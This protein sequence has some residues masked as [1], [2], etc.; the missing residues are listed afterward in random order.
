MGRN[1]VLGNRDIGVFTSS[2]SSSRVFKSFRLSKLD[3]LHSANTVAIG[4][5]FLVSRSKDSRKSSPRGLPVLETGSRPSTT[6]ARPVVSSGSLPLLYGTAWKKERTTDLVVQ[7]VVSGFRGIDTACQ[8]KHY[9]E[10]LV[11][12]ALRK[13]REQYSIDRKDLWLQTKFTPLAG[14]DKNNVPYDPNATLAEQAAQSLQKSLA[15]LGTD[16]IDSLLLHSP[17]PTGDQTMEVW[18]VFEDAVDSGTVGQLGI[19]NLYDPR[20]FHWLHANSRHKPRVLQNRFYRDS[21]YDK[22][23]RMLCLERGVTY[24]TFWTLT[25]NPHILE[26]RAVADAI[27]RLKAATSTEVTPA[28]VLFKFLIQSGHQPVTGTTSQL[29]MDQ[30][31]AAA[32]LPDLTAEEMGAITALL[33]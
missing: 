28:Q 10:D 17:L 19:S 13:L 11:G 26:S 33:N 8:P 12:A 2:A 3:V 24:Q 15:N 31:L 23:L 27:G 5:D 7:A 29:H 6:M 20:L 25:A 22:E 30:D 21:G 18:R 14:Q 9:R 16:R 1:K 4:F 32:E